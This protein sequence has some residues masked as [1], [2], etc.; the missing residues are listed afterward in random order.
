MVFMVSIS[1]P[2]KAE[3]EAGPPEAAGEPLPVHV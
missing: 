1:V 3:S 2:G